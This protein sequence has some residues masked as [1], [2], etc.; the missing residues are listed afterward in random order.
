MVE[1]YNNIIQHKHITN[2]KSSKHEEKDRIHNLKKKENE[3]LLE[4]IDNKKKQLLN[5]DLKLHIKINKEIAQLY[6]Q[7]NDVE[8]NFSAMS[9]K[10]NQSIPPELPF[11]YKTM[12]K[13]QSQ[14][15]EKLEELASL[16]NMN[17]FLSLKMSNSD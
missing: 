2:S 15:F 5:A 10:N 9:L 6:R 12:K 17:K 11:T 8:Y 16:Q 1:D 3:K 13:H 4:L 7:Y 14:T